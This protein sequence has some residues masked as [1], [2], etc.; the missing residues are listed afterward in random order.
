MILAVKPTPLECVAV[1][2]VVFVV[3]HPGGPLREP[4]EDGHDGN[5]GLGDHVYHDELIK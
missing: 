1:S 3:A 2:G 5:A 4:R